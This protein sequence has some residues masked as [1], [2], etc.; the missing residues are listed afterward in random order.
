[1]GVLLGLSGCGKVFAPKRLSP[2]LNVVKY[3]HQGCPWD[4]AYLDV[5]KYLAGDVI[6]LEIKN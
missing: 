5:V 6:Q 2:T 1:M 4:Q 3:L